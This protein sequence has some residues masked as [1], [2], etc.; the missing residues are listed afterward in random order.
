MEPMYVRG[1]AGRLSQVVT[2][3]VENAAKYTQPGGRLTVA[4]EQRDSK[5]VLRVRDSGIGIAAENLEQVF[6]PFMQAHDPLSIPSGGLGLGLS[7]T[8][9]IM[10][11]HGGR[12]EVSSGGLGMGSE[13]VVS[14][15]A[16]AEKEKE[17]EGETGLRSPEKASSPLEALGGRKVMIVD[18]HEEI[19]KSVA[20]L[21][22]RWGHEV[23]LAN[24][25]PSALSLAE[26]FQPDCAIVD[27]S[28]PGMNGIDLARRLRQRFLPVQLY[29]IALTGYAG[30]DIRERCLAAGFD[31]HLVKPGDISLLGKL[32]ERDPGGPDPAPPDGTRQA[33]EPA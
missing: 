28:L 25:G 23:A 29:L 27:L 24:D 33:G 5:A 2:N 10:E 7:L 4:V 21:V 3:L 12:V 15:L 18:D 1:D 26:T 20:R 6:E 19:R 13:F 17:K 22:R 32:L 11:L 30:A 31:A 14:L 9:R 8:R 16:A